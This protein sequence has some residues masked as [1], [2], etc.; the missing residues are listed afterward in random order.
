ML[1]GLTTRGQL[2][3]RELPGTVEG[4]IQRALATLPRAKVEAAKLVLEAVARELTREA[5][6]VDDSP[7]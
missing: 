3:N 6:R 2:L 5:Q 4:C 7:V 1:I